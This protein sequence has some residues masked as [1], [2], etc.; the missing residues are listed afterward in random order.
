MANLAINR[1]TQHQRSGC[2]PFPAACEASSTYFAELF[3]DRFNNKTNGVTQRTLLLMANPPLARLITAL[4]AWL[5]HEPGGTLKIAPLANDS[6]F[7]LAFWDARRQAK[8]NT[9]LM[10]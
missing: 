6:S 10:A 2:A 1:F 5:G 9:S 7:Q 8:E 4:L 3:P